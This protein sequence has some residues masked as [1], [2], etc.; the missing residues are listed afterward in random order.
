MKRA[1]ERLS[2]PPALDEARQRLLLL[3]QRQRL[4]ATSGTT[5]ARRPAAASSCLSFAQEGLWFLDQMEGPSGVYNS[6]LAVRLSGSLAVDVLERSVLALVERHESLR[7][8]FEQHDGNPV[9]VVKPIEAV[10]AS[11]RLEPSLGAPDLDE[12]LRA[13]VAEPF[14]LSRAPLLRA[15]LLRLG[16]DLHV[17]LLVVHHIVFDGW[18]MGVLTRELG[19]LYAAA[20]ERA[21]LPPLSI[22][23]ADY[24]SWQRERFGSEALQRQLRYW[25][26]QLAGVTPLDLPADRPRPAQISYR[27]ASERFVLPAPL[28][29]ALHALAQREGAT[30]FMLL[31]AA[32]QVL[33]MRQSRQQ[34]VA[35]GIPVAGRQRTELEGLIGYFVNTLVM[36]VDMSD[37]PGFAELLGRVRQI[38]L[39]AYANQ[40]LPFDKLVAELSPQRDLGRHPLY[41]VSFALNNQPAHALALDGL[42]VESVQLPAVVA[43]FDLSLVLVES[44]GALRGVIEYST[45]LFDASTIARMAGQYRQLLEAIVAEPTQ[46]VARLALL[47]EAEQRRLLVEWNETRVAYPQNSCV[48]ELVEAQARRNPEAVAVIFQGLPTTYRELNAQSNR[49][50]H[51]LRGWGVGPEVT[52]GLCSERSLST[53][54]AVLGI[55]KSGGAYVPLDPEHP[56]QRTAF[57][58]SDCK[59]P[60]VI[61]QRSLRE[62][63]A[64][65]A[66]AGTRLLC[67]DDD[68]PAIATQPAHDPEPLT[69]PE[70]LAYVIYTSGSTGQ[71]KGVLI[72]HRSIVNQLHWHAGAVQFQAA[73][74]FLFKTSV[75]FDASVAELLVPLVS[76]A[77]V[78]V[79]PEGVE[80]NIGELPAAIR[81]HAVTVLQM[82]PS[83]L[84]ALLGM[85]GFAAC[86]SLRY[87]ICGGEALDRELA[88]EA[89]RQLPGAVLGNFYGPTETSINSNW[90]EVGAIAPGAGTV[91]IGR[92][93]SNMRCHVLDDQLQPVPIGV[94]G[95]LCIGGVGLARGYLNRE[96]LTAERFIADPRRPGERLYRSGDLARYLPD[97]TLECVGRIDDQVKLR[98]FR[99]ELGEIEAALRACPG[100]THAAVLVREDRPGMQQLVGY[101]AGETLARTSLRDALGLSLPAY[102]IPA[103][104]VRMAAWPLLP[105]G[106]L[107]RKALPPPDHKT[108]G[109]VHEPA[110]SKIEAEL[111][112][113]W[114]DLLGLETIGVT[115][116]FFELGGHSLLAIRLLARIE[117]TFGS[118]LR[119]ATL[120]QAPTVRQLAQAI[121]Q[122]R[123]ARHS[124]VVAL[125][126]HGTRPP[127]FA[128]PGYG[129][130]I[131]PFKALA[132]EL[133]LDQPLCVLDVGAFGDEQDGFTLEELARRMIVDLL[134][135]QPTGPYYLLGASM[136]GKIVYEIAQQLVRAGHELALLA[137][138]D[139]SAPGYPRRAS[140]VVRTW[141]HLRHGL[142]MEPAQAR[143]YLAE[144]VWRLR[145]YL[146]S[147]RPQL[148]DGGAE[149]RLQPAKAMQE[150]ADAVARA[151]ARYVPAF[152]PGRVVL[153][154]AEVR[155]SYPGVIDDDLELG[156]G[157]FV[158]GGVLRESMHCAHREMLTPEFAPPLAAVLVKHLV[159]R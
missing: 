42:Q 49:L 5:I 73:D 131:V 2:A 26:E 60:V 29:A 32:F 96:E 112:G 100:V 75:S 40:E 116:D 41:Q 120:F 123:A 143:R 115:D 103:A 15:R 78:V 102:M 134:E 9:Q 76:G 141:L 118:V 151:C 88:R 65:L 11:L 101:V 27:G 10:A 17:L 121:Q 34:N 12:W 146:V 83:T 140:F 25:R 132:G 128:V 133:G 137:L 56:V 147:I 142:A 156:W 30:L 145:K 3:R 149:A 95:E 58:L 24:A 35:V 139:C 136:G 110:G 18:S 33:L 90:H 63:I 158:G 82:V 57:M 150:S 81:S 31:L 92:P 36:R 148:F 48:H 4:A 64:G 62:R 71:P 20:G 87:L 157:P 93:V 127:L 39:D 67:L 72:E 84:R 122:Q 114:S 138:L 37:N 74:R 111:L 125:Q 50:A 43:K 109:T 105:N 61:T 117:E 113:I 153:I 85:P 6:A 124:C 130:G 79:A 44:G 59:A 89:R 7:T 97:G 16:D 52:V 46:R 23:F 77:C 38:S 22:Q 45:D 8:A 129:G 144:R 66:P 126:P 69:R 106:K 104:I 14:E 119:V 154:R 13:G 70:H 53:L 47:G 107:D 98:G 28:Q 159:P 80:R 19:A 68:A 99:I 55:L 91:P 94:A 135:R 152:Y 86:T 108:S 1:D 54:V 155:P 51:Q 21:A